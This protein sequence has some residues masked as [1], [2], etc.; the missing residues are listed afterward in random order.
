MAEVRSAH[1]WREAWESRMA[2]CGYPL[3]YLEIVHDHRAPGGISYTW[4]EDLDA[5]VMSHLDN[6]KWEGTQ[7]EAWETAHQ[8]FVEVDHLR[9]TGIAPSVKLAELLDERNGRN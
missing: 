3:A 5:W 2:A 8:V 7:H 9:P 6:T 4:G 1:A